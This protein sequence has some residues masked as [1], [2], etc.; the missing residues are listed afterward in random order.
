MVHS[1]QVHGVILY[2]HGERYDITCRLILSSLQRPCLFS[3]YLDIIPQWLCA[4]MRLVCLD[5]W[6]IITDHLSYTDYGSGFN[7][8][9][10]SD[11]NIRH[12]IMQPL[13]NH[14]GYSA[15]SHYLIQNWA[16][17]HRTKWNTI[18]C[19][20][21]LNRNGTSFSIRK[22]NLKASLTKMRP[23]CLRLNVISD[24]FIKMLNSSALKSLYTIANPTFELISWH[25]SPLSIQLVLLCEAWIEWIQCHK[26]DLT[27]C[28][29]MRN[30]FGLSASAQ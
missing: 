27:Y 7:S 11:V 8:S 21:N 6:D 24:G 29:W 5:L 16:I 22:K 26:I 3:I 20:V 15:P 28:F 14:I 12:Q 19:Y 23:I 18:Q 9:R 30:G 4:G 13:I 10:S 2:I 25:L 17:A 1:T